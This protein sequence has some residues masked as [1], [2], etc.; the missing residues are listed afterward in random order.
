MSMEYIQRY[1][2]VPARI[3]GRIRYTGGRHAMLGTITESQGRYIMVQ[4]DGQQH[5]MPYHPTWEIEYLDGQTAN[6]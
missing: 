4:L 6:A 2:S 1:Y 3:G 5:S